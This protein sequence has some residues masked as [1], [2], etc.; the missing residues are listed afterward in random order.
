MQ[1]KMDAH[2]GHSAAQRPLLLVWHVHVSQLCRSPRQG[3]GRMH[4]SGSASPKGK[5]NLADNG[6]GLV[7]CPFRSASMQ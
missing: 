4:S 1:D 5:V 3:E 6:H 2:Q 7:A